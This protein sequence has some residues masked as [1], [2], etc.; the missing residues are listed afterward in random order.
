[1]V[2]NEGEGIIG[3]HSNHSH[4][5][6]Q[7]ASCIP[8]LHHGSKTGMDSGFRRNDVRGA[9]NDMADARNDVRDARNDMGDARNDMGDARNDM[10]TSPNP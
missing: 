9:R 7:P 1:M 4:Q 10:S 6:S 5:S 3:H 8:S 2:R